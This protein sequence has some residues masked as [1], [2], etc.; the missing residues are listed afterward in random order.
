[1]D[2]YVYSIAPNLLKIQDTRAMGID[3]AAVRL[4]DSVAPIVL[5]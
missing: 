2:D 3:L 5:R 4:D 1:M